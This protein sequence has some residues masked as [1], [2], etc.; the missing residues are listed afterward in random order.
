M[1]FSGEMSGAFSALGLFLSYWVYAKTTNLQLAVGVF[2]FFLM[3]FLQ[4][5]QYWYIND[6][7]NQMNKI[8][9]FV[10]FAH[11][12]Y[13]PYFTHVINSALTRSEKVLHMYVPVLRLCLI[14]GTMLLFRSIIAMYMDPSWT[15]EHFAK[16]DQIDHATGQSTVEGLTTS[17][18]WLRGEQ[19]CTVRGKYHLAWIVPM[20]DATYYV[21][22]AS[23][24]SF[25]MFAPFFAIKPNMMIQGVFLWAAGPALAAYITPNLMEQASIW[26][27]FSIAQIGI[28]LY[29]I[30]EVLLLN[31][32]RGAEEATKGGK[33]QSRSISTAQD[34][35]APYLNLRYIWPTGVV[36]PGS[37]EASGKCHVS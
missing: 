7:D 14:G 34:G 18:E 17:K 19:L 4:Y 11:I 30:R 3:E 1:C 36:I 35:T 6:C 28:M 5:F 10:G 12:C 22:A 32:G 33:K 21:P 25:L 37:A 26:C 29:L 8:L 23:I 9:T 20:A 31:Y 27:F 24:H 13:Q 2:Y 16:V 15:T